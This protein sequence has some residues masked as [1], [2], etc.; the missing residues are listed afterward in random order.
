MAWPKTASPFLSKDIAREPEL[1]GKIVAAAGAARTIQLIPYA[2]TPE[3]MRLVQILREDYS[4]N[5][6]LP[7]TPD[8]NNIWVRNYIDTKSGFRAL[9]SRWLPN[10]EN[11]LVEG[12]VCLDVERAAEI[13]SWFL[14]EKRTCVIK[15]DVGESGLGHT[16]F[17]PGTDTSEV[18]IRRKLSENP[19]ITS[20]VIVV[21][22]YVHSSRN[23]SP[24]LEFIVPRSGEAQITYLSDQLFLDDFGSSCGVL[25]SKAS[26]HTAWYETFSEAGLRVARKLQQLGYVGHFDLDAIVDDNENI[27]LLEINARR[28]AGTHAHEFAQHC[29]G[30]DYL[31]YSVVLCHNKLHCPSGLEL[32]DILSC[33]EDLSLTCGRSKQG[34]VISASSGITSGEYGCI[35]VSDSVESA[36]ALLSLVNNRVSGFRLG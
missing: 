29:L 17:S 35:C 13:V 32:E 24:S 25:I 11:L 19:Y 9:V 33:I 30:S 14:G 28:T 22:E 18:D 36:S 26:Q 31:E 20:G 34:V 21:E 23:L 4:L 7:E 27:Y 15:S 6:V 8:E 1:T 3:F 5:L 10:A 16:I 2:S 12:Y